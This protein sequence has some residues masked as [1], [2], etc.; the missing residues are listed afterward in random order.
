MCAFSD[1]TDMFV[2]QLA[3]TGAILMCVCLYTLTIGETCGMVSIK[4]VVVIVPSGLYVAS[5]ITCTY[6]LFIHGQQLIY[7]SIIYS[8]IYLLIVV[9]M[10]PLNYD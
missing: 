3:D 8:I 6:F 10:Q 4:L 1:K 2:V 5:P 7:H 9:Y